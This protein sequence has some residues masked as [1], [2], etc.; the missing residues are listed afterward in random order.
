MVNKSK[1]HYDADGCT[2]F[3]YNFSKSKILRASS[4]INV[5]STISVQVD[6]FNISC[7]FRD[8]YLDESL[9]S[10]SY[11]KNQICRNCVGYCTLF[12]FF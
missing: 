10:F 8:N 6:T 2:G 4:E 12:I 11:H 1:S 7:Y 9:Q 5:Q 3:F